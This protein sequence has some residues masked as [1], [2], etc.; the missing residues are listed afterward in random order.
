MRDFSPTSVAS[1]DI[2]ASVTGKP[3][4]VIFLTT[5]AG[6]PFMLIA[7]YSPGTIVQ[8]ATRAMMP[9]SISVIIAP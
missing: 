9:T 8:A 5:A 3:R 7:K 6:S 1:A 4:S 2:W